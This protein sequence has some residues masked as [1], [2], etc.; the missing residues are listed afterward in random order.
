MATALLALTAFS[1]VP[2]LYG[3]NTRIHNYTPKGDRSP[4]SGP[5]PGIVTRSSQLTYSQDHGSQKTSAWF[6]RPSPD[7]IPRHTAPR[8]AP[9]HTCHACPSVDYALSL[10]R[11]LTDPTNS[12]LGLPRSLA[13]SIK[14]ISRVL[15]FEVEY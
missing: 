9:T 4:S 13:V 12:P 8:H 15:R 3:K 2:S 6:Y 5:F 10:E 14:L 11:L 7:T 1:G